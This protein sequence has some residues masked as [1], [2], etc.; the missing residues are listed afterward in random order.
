MK[1]RLVLIIFVALL[2]GAGGFVYYGQK[3][4]K[5]QEI[6]DKLIKKSEQEYLSPYHIALVY[7]ALGEA[8]K[9]FDWM[10]KAYQ[11]LDYWL[12]WLKIEP[13]LN[14]VRSDPRFKALLEKLNF[15]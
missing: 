2:I 1:K 9:G 4:E 15:E 8:D 13:T 10:N 14:E 5:A 11:E 12:N 7:F 3:K 6:L